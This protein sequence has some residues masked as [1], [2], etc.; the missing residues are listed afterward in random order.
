MKPYVLISHH[1][2]ERLVES[3]SKKEKSPLL[4]K[5]VKDR[6]LSGLYT[7]VEN[8]KKSKIDPQ[9]VDQFIQENIKF[10]K[11]LNLSKFDDTAKTLNEGFDWSECSLIKDI[12][13]VLFE[14]KNVYN[15][16]DYTNSYR[17][18]KNHLINLSEK[19]NKIRETLDNL[20]ER[21]ESLDEDDKVLFENYVKHED[22]KLF[23][24]NEVQKYLEVLQE[25]IDTTTDLEDKVALF[26]VKTTILESKFE[27]DEDIKKMLE[28]HNLIKELKST[29]LN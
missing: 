1:I 12:N 14:Q 19:D 21:L 7:I 15:L 13:T 23:V 5:V 18:V 11:T 9:D 17:R 29:E 4:N 16:Q 2:S 8:L 27:G 3:F 28:I 24:E 10:A 6:D 25:M 20:S 22:K 26:K